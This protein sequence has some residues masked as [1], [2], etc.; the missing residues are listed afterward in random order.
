MGALPIRDSS[1]VELEANPRVVWMVTAA[2]SVLVH[3][4]AIAVASSLVAGLDGSGPRLGHDLAGFRVDDGLAF[5]DLDVAIDPRAAVA[6]VDDPATVI[7]TAPPPTPPAPEIPVEPAEA[8]VGARG[9]FRHP[10]ERPAPANRLPGPPLDP[11]QTRDFVGASDRGTG[12]GRP[13]DETAWRRDTST[14][15]ERLSD[16]ADSYQPPRERTSREARPSSPQAVRRE[17]AP[18]EGDS[19]RTAV[20][21]APAPPASDATTEDPQGT[22]PPASRMREAEDEPPS[23][24]TDAADDVARHGPRHVTVATSGPLDADRGPRLFD[25]RA[26]RARVPTDDRDL[27]AAS[28]E[29]HPSLLDLSLAAA[30]GTST[31]G[32]GPGETPGA[33]TKASRGLAAAVTRPHGLPGGTGDEDS[34]SE[35]TYNRYNLEL[36]RRVHDAYSFPKDLALRLEQGETIV[37][38]TVAPDGRLSGAAEVVKSSGFPGFDQAALD[39]VAKALPFPHMPDPA[40][41]R[42]LRFSVRFAASNPVIW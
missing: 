38:F 28:R 32:R 40:H 22:A 7:P 18:G 2:V 27:R 8:P 20:L 41:A 14:A 29:L 30:A 21:E 31:E 11:R 34:L 1:T 16:G 39:A 36:R 23:P 33:L 13:V 17:P 35:R 25:V 12:L 3:A 15:H 9:D 19:A 42:P 4:I 37:R 6:P 24:P 10:T 5:V 26:G